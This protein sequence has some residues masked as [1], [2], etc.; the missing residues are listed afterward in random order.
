MVLG[1]GVPLTASAILS[2]GANA[3]GTITFTLYNPS[4]TSVYTDVVSVTGNGTY[5]TGTGTITGSAL[6]TLPGT[7]QWVAAYNGDSNNNGISTTLGSTSEVAV[8]PGATM[9]GNALYL[10]G[11]KTNDQVNIQPI[12]LSNTGIQVQ[13]QLN[14][15]NL[16]NLTYSPSPAII[17]IVGFNGNDNITMANT[18]TIAAVVSEGDGNDNIQLGQGNNTLIAGNG[19]DNVQAGNGSNTVTLGNGNDNVQLGDG[20]NTVFLGNGNDNVHLGNGNNIATTGNGN[21]NIQAGNGDN[22]LVAGLG[23]HSV[24]AGNG[25]NILIDGSATLQGS[26][27]LSQV[28]NEWVLDGASAAS[29][30]RTQLSVTDNTSHPNKLSAGKGIDWFWATYAKDAVNSKTGDLLN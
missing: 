18:V 15:V 13:G 14:G 30:I 20:N 9:V 16:H 4:N 21:D 28:L 10:V 1:T 6:P 24:T 23:Q 22:L 7:Y 5:S 12:G 3:T 17:Y 2:G 25:S 8:G 19:N 29:L 26:A 11:G 27:T